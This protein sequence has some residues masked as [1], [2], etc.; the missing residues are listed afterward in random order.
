MKKYR[1]PHGDVLVLKRGEELMNTLKIDAQ[2]NNFASAWLQ[3]GLGGAESVVLSFYDLNTKEY[4]D[5]TF[6]ESLE[7]V[8]LQGNLSSVDGELFW[9]VHGTFGRRDYQTISG[10]VKELTIA[11]TGELLIVPL[12]T[13]L[14]RMYDE[15]TGLQLLGNE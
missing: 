4:K 9:H 2:E 12:E 13:P 11:L 8:S 6:N 3:S 1:N 15:T 7:I 10:H 14:T 5:K